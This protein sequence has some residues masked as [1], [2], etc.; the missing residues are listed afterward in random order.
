MGAIDLI[1]NLAALLLWLNWRSMALDPLAMSPPTTLVG[2]LRRAE[3]R[4]AKRWPLLAAILALLFIRAVLYWQ[5]GPAADWTPSLKLGV[6]TLSFRHDFFA[7]A[8][9]FSGLSFVFTLVVF[10]A[11]LLFVSLVNSAAPDEEPLQKL[12]RLHLG[13]FERL[14][15]LARLLG[16]LL[17]SALIWL[18]IAPLLT[19]WQIIPRPLSVLH[20]MEQAGAIG[21][22]VYLSWKYLILPL[23]LVYLI[24]SYVY[25]GRHAVWSFISLTGR[26]LLKPARFLPLRIGRLDFAP[27]I[28]IPA[29]IFLWQVAGRSLTRLYERLPL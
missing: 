21:L 17:A 10:Y 29:V 2:T 13:W 24:N 19:N 11:W 15:W 23:L 27:V 8:L 3:P 4:R 25:L 7:R 5:L 16:P 22:G 14:P 26:N 28:A 20:R 1:L 12:V 6:I 18:A 9:A